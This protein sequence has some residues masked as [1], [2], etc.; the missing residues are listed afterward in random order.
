MEQKTISMDIGDYNISITPKVKESKKPEP[1]KHL[2]GDTIPMH[3]LGNFDIIEKADD[4][5]II[6]G[7]GSVVEIDKENHIIPKKALEE[8]IETLLKD[9]DYSNLMLVHRNI[10][11][12]KILKE[13]N[14]LKTHVNDKGLF[15]VAEVRN[16][17]E[18]S[19]EIWKLIT[20]GDLNAFSI[21][22]EIILSHDEC[23]DEKCIKVIDKLNIYEVSVCQTPMNKGS[24]FIVVSKGDDCLGDVIDNNTKGVITKMSDEECKDC[25][26]KQEEHLKKADDDP[27]VGETTKQEDV[28]P[29]E[30]QD[31]EVEKQDEPSEDIKKDDAIESIERRISAIEESI[32]SL[33]NKTEEEPEQESKSDPDP[34]PEEPVEK[35]DDMDEEEEEEMEEEEEEW[36]SKKGE[37]A[38]KE[39]VD[40]LRKSLEELV[41]S[42]KTNEEIGKLETLIKSKDDLISNLQLKVETLE[43]AEVTPKTTIKKDDEEED[44]EE[45]TTSSM[46]HKDSL[47]TGVWYHNP[48]Y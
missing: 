43:K 46:L 33:I 40:A 24:G 48:D 2:G 13:Y 17:L 37:Y 41:K 25:T 9:S 18:T 31:D 11:V 34:E 16:D 8:G 23:D 1:I 32:N 39:D 5:R 26:E 12:G 36:Q 42:V 22:G 27:A 14:D 44:K 10:Q 19:N 6:A 4:R 28:E 38:T 7:Y 20:N 35:Q 29:T 3:L 21:A 15:I 30:K 45:K 47:G